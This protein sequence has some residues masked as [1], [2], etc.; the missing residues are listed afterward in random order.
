MHRGHVRLARGALEAL[1]GL[2]EGLDFMP[3]AWPPHKSGRHFLPF[4]LRCR[5][6]EASID[7]LPRARVNGME[8]ARQAPSYT[9]D[10]LSGLR[11]AWPQTEIF[12][13]LGSEDFAQLPAWRNGLGLPGLCSFAVAP[14]G[15]FSQGDFGDLCRSLWPLAA[16]GEE[17]G[18]LSSYLLPGG[19]RALFLPIVWQDI[20]STRIRALWQ[21]GEDI[22]GLVPGGALE[23]MRKNRRIILDCWQEK[24]DNAQGSPQGNA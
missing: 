20:S 13:L 16:R 11:A 9:W 12:F 15:D 6:L 10:S 8:G 7:G 3:C 2:A 14:R 4:G 5:M 18:N 1:A 19:G 24:R 23:I 17:C 22:S 21:A